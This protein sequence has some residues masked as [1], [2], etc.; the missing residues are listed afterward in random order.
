MPPPPD[1]VR[2]AVSG[3]ASSSSRPS[4]APLLPQSQP[5]SKS[6]T[7]SPETAISQLNPNAPN[8]KPLTTLIPP[9]LPSTPAISSRPAKAPTYR[10]PHR[11]LATNTK[12]NIIRQKEETEQRQKQEQTHSTYAEIAKHA[13]Q[14]TN[15]PQHTLTLTNQ[16]H[17]KLT[18]L[19]IEAHIAALDK[20][21]KFGD[22]LTQSLKLNFNIDTTSPNRDSTV[23]FN[24]YYNKTD[25]QQPQMTQTPPQEEHTIDQTIDTAMDETDAATYTEIRQKRRISDGVEDSKLLMNNKYTTYVKLYR[26][27]ED[28]SPIPDNPTKDWFANE[29][30]KDKNND[31]GLKVFTQDLDHQPEMEMLRKRRALFLYTKINTIPH[32]QFISLPRVFAYH[33]LSDSSCYAVDFAL[34]QSP[35]FLDLLPGGTDRPTDHHGLPTKRLQSQDL[36]KNSHHLKLGRLVSESACEWKDPGSNPA[37]DMVDA[38]RNT[39]WDLGKQPNNYRSNYPTQE[40]AKRKLGVGV[41]TVGRAVAKLGGKSHVIFE[42]L[43]LMPAIRTKRL[44]SCQRLMNNLKSSP[45]G[46]AIIFLDEKTWTFH[47]VQ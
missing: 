33:F 3:R 43:L 13:V 5:S 32:K 9:P 29:L 41:A 16:T 35:S 4:R 11:T 44:E 31:N 23:I 8:P 25:S 7:S 37:A 28:S 18:A 20:T 27:Y 47:P 17:I 42:R 10:G 22:I 14:Q 34:E 24:F 12:K 46:Q 38:A 36:H 39:A 15:P 45:P 30:D 26:N 1:R 40:W 21:K 19:I 2:G 6:R